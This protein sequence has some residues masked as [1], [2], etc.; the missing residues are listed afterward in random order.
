M[1]LVTDNME[2]KGLQRRGQLNMRVF[3]SWQP[4][5]C[6]AIKPVTAGCRVFIVQV[7]IITG[8]GDGCQVCA[9]GTSKWCK[10]NK[11]TT[12]VVAAWELRAWHGSLGN[13][14][15]SGVWI[16][17]S[18]KCRR[19]FWRKTGNS[20][21]LLLVSCSEVIVILHVI[22]SGGAAGLF[23]VKSLLFFLS[24]LVVELQVCL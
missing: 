18:E 21:H 14:W 5:S 9:C 8:C 7:V 24:W 1:L 11:H 22:A 10:D 12:D 6:M 17:R 23:V 3:F 19:W 13:W 4:I 16:H 20:G 15:A 2:L